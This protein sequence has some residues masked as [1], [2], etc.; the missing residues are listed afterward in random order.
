ME[1]MEGIVEKEKVELSLGR[2]NKLRD[3]NKKL[4]E[5]IARFK[6]ERDKICE[7]NKVRIII[8]DVF[9]FEQ[10]EELVNFDDVRE[11]VEKKFGTTIEEL[12]KENEKLHD[13]L[14]KTKKQ[15]SEDLLELE[16]EISNLR[17]RGL[18]QRIWNK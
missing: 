9:G 10:R 7:K 18:W 16:M 17:H 5:E 11:D 1:K 15:A 12:R 3:E 6:D 4:K 14:E 2:Y 8:N 13:E